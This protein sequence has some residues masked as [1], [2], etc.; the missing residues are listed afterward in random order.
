M[1]QNPMRKSYLDSTT[2][3]R[4]SLY[5]IPTNYAANNV[6]VLKQ[7]VTHHNIRPFQCANPSYAY[8]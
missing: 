4:Y 3:G 6:Q 1:W 2:I 8:L 5:L 7:K